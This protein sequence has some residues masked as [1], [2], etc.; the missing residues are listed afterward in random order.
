MQIIPVI[1][2][3]GGMAVHAL[4][5]ERERYAPVQG[6]FTSGGDAVALA[7][8]YRDRLGCRACYVADL[9]AIAGAPGHAALLRE[10]AALGLALWVD[11]GVSSAAAAWQLSDIGVSKIIV[12]SES[13]GSADQIAAL[14]GGFPAGR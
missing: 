8:S 9:D 4:R 10:L 14:A 12:G 1:D 7:T 13:L 2:L 11:A 6:L 5:G 3:K